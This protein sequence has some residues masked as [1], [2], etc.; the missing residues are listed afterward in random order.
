V[1]L[2]NTERVLHKLPL[3]SP[4]RP[5]LE[6]VLAASRRARGVIDQI[7]AFS[8]RG[9]TRLEPISPSDVFREAIALIRSTL[10]ASI[11]MRT[12][13]ARISG[14]V[15]GDRNQLHQVVMNLCTNAYHAMGEAGVLTVSVE[16]VRVG[17]RSELATSGLPP[18]DYAALEVTDTGC[19]IDQQSTERIFEPFYTTKQGAGT[20]LGLSTVHGI[21]TALGGQVRVSS[22]PGEGSTFRIYLPLQ[23][24][25]EVLPEAA[26]PIEPRR[27]HRGRV[28][29]VD[30]QPSVLETLAGMLE[31]LG[32]EVT[33]CREGA[34]AIEKLR[35]DATGY[36]AM[37]TDQT[38][39]GMTGLDLARSVHGLRS[40]LPVLLLSGYS[41]VLTEESLAANHVSGFLPKP[42]E[43]DDLE[44]ALERV[45][46]TPVARVEQGR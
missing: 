25:I 40:D 19:G 12:S 23:P 10:P 36:L 15:I 38:M 1:I 28:L 37:I 16:E 13:F 39:P 30:D 29:I 7:L 31:D 17:P 3:A 46:T 24:P 26:E 5:M 11:Q 2:G 35:S 20:G 21:V 32:Y 14:V 43:F 8:R 6:N 45:T 18:G 42:L 27:L 9:E 22:R 4:L 33:S 41:S 44:R 34:E